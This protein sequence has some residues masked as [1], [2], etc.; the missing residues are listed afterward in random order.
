MAYAGDS[1]MAIT[2]GD[3][4]HAAFFPGVTLNYAENLLQGNPESMA[5]ASYDESGP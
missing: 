1:S 5:I 3:I 4:E 2:E